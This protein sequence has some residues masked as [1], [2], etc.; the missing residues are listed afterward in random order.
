MVEKKVEKVVSGI[1]IKRKRGKGEKLIALVQ[2]EN[3][4]SLP[5][6]ELKPNIGDREN[7]GNYLSKE[8]F[9]GRVGINQHYISFVC[10]KGSKRGLD[11]Y[12][13]TEYKNQKKMRDYVRWFDRDELISNEEHII[14]KETL[15]IV[16][17]LISDKYL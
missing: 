10:G 5:K 15:R 7:L 12:F 1:V 8:V 3:T 2:Y 13:A 16:K 11:A 9:G 4:W 6:I 17:Y 14:S